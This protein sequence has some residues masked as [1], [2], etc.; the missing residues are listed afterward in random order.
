MEVKLGTTIN[1]SKKFL[2]NKSDTIPT[3]E[4]DKNYL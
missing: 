4:R 3:K 2:P 1:F